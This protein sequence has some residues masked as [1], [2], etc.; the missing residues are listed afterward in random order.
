VEVGEG[1]GPVQ[2]DHVPGRTPLGHGPAGDPDVSAAPTH[3]SLGRHCDHDPRGQAPQPGHPP[4]GTRASREHRTADR[5]DRSP[6]ETL[7]TL[8]GRWSFSADVGT[9]TEVRRLRRPMP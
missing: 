7:P 1:V 4:F 9:E 5:G 8:Q 3:C 2:N 6:V